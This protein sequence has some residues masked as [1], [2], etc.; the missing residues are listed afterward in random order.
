MHYGVPAYLHHLSPFGELRP[1]IRQSERQ[2]HVKLVA[3]LT[4]RSG[5]RAW[6]TGA[7]LEGKCWDSVDLLR[8]AKKPRPD[9]VAGLCC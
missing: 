2:W 6:H 4:L 3:F 7:K 9:W 1:I 8:T 5:R